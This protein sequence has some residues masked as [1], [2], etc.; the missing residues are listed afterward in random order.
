MQIN[1]AFCTANST[2]RFNQMELAYSQLGCANQNKEVL[3]EDGSCANGRGIQISIGWNLGSHFIRL[4]DTC[5]DKIASMN[6][7]S[8]HTI[9]GRSVD[10]DD[11]SNKRPSFRQAGYYPGVDVNAA[12]SQGHQNKTIAR[13]VGSDTLVAKYLNQKKNLFL[14]RGHLAPDGDFIDAGSQDAT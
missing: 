8:T 7:Y 3:K 9:I 4:Y 5:H 14:A 12:F 10:A 2:L 11:K 6:Y 13:V 1:Q